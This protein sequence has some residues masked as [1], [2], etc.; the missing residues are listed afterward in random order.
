MSNDGP[1]PPVAFRVVDASLGTLTLTWST[2]DGG[3]ARGF[4]LFKN[5]KRVAST[6]ETGFT[7]TDLPCGAAYTL[8]VKA[9]DADGRRSE[10]TAVIAT[11][12]PCAPAPAVAPPPPE[13]ERESPLPEPGSRPAGGVW[14]GAGAFIWRE[15]A[16]APETLGSHL[17]EN[18]FSW[19]AVLIH[20][21]MDAD[22]IEDNWVGRFRAASG[23]R[24]GGWG[25]LRTHP[26]REAALAHRLLAESSLD[27][28]IAN[29][30]AEYKYSGDDG[31]SA[32]RY[33]RSRRFVDS[34]R[35]LEPDTPSAISSYCRADT[36]DI[37]WETWSR[38]GF[39]FLPQAY[40]NDFG[41]SVTPTACVEGATQFFPA[42][43]VHPT[44]GVYAGQET[45]L[46]PQR[47]GAL[48]D[49]AGT[50]GFS[51]YLAET[52]MHAQQW[53]AYGEAISELAIARRAD[54][55]TVRNASDS[56]E[57]VEKAGRP[58]LVT[59]VDLDRAVSPVRS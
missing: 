16:V 49:E 26:E 27:F 57:R 7:F 20:D 22:P 45:E 38:S 29:A 48:L 8:G 5:G 14:A 11:P 18:G 33:G 43:A 28:Y 53:S 36:Q 44:V 32:D 47:Y 39:V 6:T 3:P 19:A 51:V 31:T 10:L 34:F 15:T 41:A 25:V 23:L 55:D 54:S 56:D 42:T 21:G 9:F 50:V 59:R 4:E 12:R 13:P 35:T 1:K 30:E 52:G 46:S 40:V 2:V 17:R 37:D 24:V 58:S